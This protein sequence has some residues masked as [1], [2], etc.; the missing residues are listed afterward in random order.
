MDPLERE[1]AQCGLVGDAESSGVAERAPDEG[2][3]LVDDEGRVGHMGEH[4]VE[5]LLLACVDRDRRDE[6]VLHQPHAQLDEGRQADSTCVDQE[7]VIVSE[8]RLGRAVAD[9]L[10]R[11]GERRAVLV[12]ELVPEGPADEVLPSHPQLPA[13]GVVDGDHVLA[14]EQDDRAGE[15]FHHGGN[16]GMLTYRPIGLRSERDVCLGAGLSQQG[17]WRSPSG[18]AS[19]RHPRR[20][21]GP[22]RRPSTG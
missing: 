18:R 2:G 19:R 15:W 12:E 21:R 7:E 4:G 22:G 10:E 13:G 11:R 17:A 5:P 1:L 3:L 14:V 20:S 9:A 6:S 16:A 8:V